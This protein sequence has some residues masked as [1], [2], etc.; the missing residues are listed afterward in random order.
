MLI[1]PGDD[2]EEEV[3]IAGVVGQVGPDERAMEQTKLSTIC[4]AGECYSYRLDGPRYPLVSSASK[5]HTHLAVNNKARRTR[6]NVPPNPDKP[7]SRGVDIVNTLP[8]SHQ[9]AQPFLAFCPAISSCA[10][11]TPVPSTSA[12]SLGAA[13]W[14]AAQCPTGRGW[15]WMRH[16]SGRVGGNTRAR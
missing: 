12:S 4:V 14:L 9:N 8:R 1:S 2:L 11:E 16:R 7:V 6:N 13:E 10:G 3:G 15:R 5:N